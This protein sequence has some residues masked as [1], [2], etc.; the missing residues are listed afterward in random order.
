MSAVELFNFVTGNNVTEKDAAAFTQHVKYSRREMRM[1]VEDAS[2]VCLQVQD[3]FKA[4]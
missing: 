2:N 1:G 4:P 3:L